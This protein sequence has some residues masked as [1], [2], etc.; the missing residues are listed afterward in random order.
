MHYRAMIADDYEA[1]YRLWENTAGM[2]LSQADSREEICAFFAE[3][4]ILIYQS[5]STLFMP[6]MPVMP[7]MPA[8][9]GPQSP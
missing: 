9:N 8:A 7:V 3:Y 2:Q 4:R 5:D 6:V 1:A